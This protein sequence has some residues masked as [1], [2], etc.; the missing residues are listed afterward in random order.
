MGGGEQAV[1]GPHIPWYFEERLFL[2]SVP[3]NTFCTTLSAV[4]DSLWCPGVLAET[5]RAPALGCLG[6][7]QGNPG[8]AG[9]SK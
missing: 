4:R 3:A 7:E 9:A 6:T 1:L 8:A 2:L 5:D